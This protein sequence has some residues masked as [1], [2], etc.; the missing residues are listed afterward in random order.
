MRATETTPNSAA[1]L[2]SIVIPMH[3]AAA[4]LPRTLDSL[5]Q[6]TFCTFEVI[7]VD[8][9]S[10]DQTREVAEQYLVDRRFRLICLPRNGGV[11][12]ARNEGIEHAKGDYL[13]FLDADDW[14]HESKL[15]I[16]VSA[17]V[18]NAWDLSYMEYLRVQEGTN[19]KLSRVIPPATLDFRQ[20]LKS[21]YI[22]N[23][24]AMIR[25]QAIGDIRFSKAGHEDYI[26][27]LAILKKGVAAYRVPTDQPLCF[28][29]VRQGSLSSN[30]FKALKWQWRI[31][32]DTLGLSLVQATWYLMWYMVNALKK[33][34]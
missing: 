16:Q 15:E 12:N 6:Q 25:R 8:D 32:R 23:L 34:S 19:R 29:L 22:G 31:Y 28:Y 7:M 11:A 3:N 30:K 24:T 21:N 10:T 9:Y 26:F 1:P 33:R 17:M 13:C 20:L 4:I 5:K 14:W 18:T 27:W 2:V